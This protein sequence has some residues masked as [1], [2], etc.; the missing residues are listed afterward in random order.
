LI[1]RQALTLGCFGEAVIRLRLVTITLFKE[2]AIICICWKWQGSD[3]V[4]SDTWKDDWD[5]RELLKNFMEVAAN[6][7]EIVGHNGDRFDIRWL[8]TR[9]L[10]HGIPAFPSYKTL[11]T[12]KKLRSGF[13]FNSNRL[14]YIGQVLGV[15]KKIETSYSLWKD[16]CLRGCP[17]S[18]TKMVDYCKEDVSLLE[19]V[20]ERI[21][22]YIKH[23]THSAVLSGGEKWQCP[24]CES[25][26]VACNKTRTT[27][28]GTIKREMKCGECSKYY[29]IS[30]RDYLN[31]LEWRQ[32]EKNKV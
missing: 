24:E 16:I 13:Y 8:R 23:N 19:R 5:D 4:Y 1:L 10:I 20:Y 28:A 7:D 21:M 22:P 27:A 26:N 15:G 31:L 11:D 2:R 14:D 12:L 3:E 30:N 25:V 18:M 17:E 29:T 6:A 9:C 32:E